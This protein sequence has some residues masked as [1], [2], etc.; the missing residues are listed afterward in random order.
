MPFQPS[1]DQLSFG[2]MKPLAIL[3]SATTLLVGSASASLAE[4]IARRSNETDL[5]FAQRAL[6]LNADAAP[7]VVSA[8]WNG[9]PTLFVDYE[10][11]K[12][13]ETNRPLVALMK[14]PDGRYRSVRVTIGEE[15]GAEATFDAVGFAKADRTDN[16]ALITILGWDQ[17]HHDLVSGTLYEVR[18]FPAPRPGQTDLTPLAISKHFDGGCECWHN[19]GGPKQKPYTTHFRFKTI[20]AVKAELKKLGYN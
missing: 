11:I 15:E 4:D 16:K 7:H 8:D 14:L 17:N 1:R 19:D 2:G 9:V 10:E 18:I 13:G 20:A 5:A 3:L 12:G 6:R